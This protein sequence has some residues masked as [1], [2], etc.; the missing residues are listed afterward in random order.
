[1]RQ[2]YEVVE[3]GLGV[4]G[5]MLVVQKRVLVEARAALSGYV[6]RG[7]LSLPL[8]AGFLLPFVR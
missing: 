2:L 6:V 5:T 3:E 8:V 4:A 1:M 7:G